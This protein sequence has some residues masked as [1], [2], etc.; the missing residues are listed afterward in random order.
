MSSANPAENAAFCPFFHHAIELIGRRWTGAILRAML[1]GVI[2]FS[3]LRNAV[4]ELSDRM[5]SERLKEL[6]HEGIVH[7]DVYPE[8]PVRIEYRLTAKGEALAPVLESVS[9]WAHDWLVP[10][11]APAAA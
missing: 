5:L 3:E 2:R 11:E 7:R 1:G 9:A 8:I 4:P 6:E 10:Q